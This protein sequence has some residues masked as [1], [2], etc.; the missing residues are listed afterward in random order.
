MVERTEV[1]GEAA[2]RKLAMDLTAPLIGVVAGFVVGVTSTGGG[3]LLTPALVF[4]LR[5]P[6]SIAVGS[7]VLIATVT[8]L[9]GGGLYA[10]RGQVHWPTV[11]RLLAGSLPGA[12]LGIVV[13]NHIPP[14]VREDALQRALGA[15]LV[16]AGAATLGRLYF[17][18]HARPTTAPGAGWTAA[19][20]FG[21]GLLVSTTSIGSGS[22]LLCVLT[23]F[24]PLP[25]QTM[26]G[27]D[28]VHA[29]VLS[30]AATVGHVQAGRVDVA[31]AAS[32]LAGSV[33]GVILGARVAHVVPERA[34]RAV[35]AVILMGLGVPIAW[36][37]ALAYVHVG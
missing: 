5:V 24:F 19:L 6:P 20:G 8:K 28:L 27:T 14:A 26:V 35:L 11:W 15:V 9:F 37:G 29:L 32:V 25:A 4:I 7:D 2:E 30:A 17:A 10:L 12:A 33:P 31:L 36:P 16:L 22:L 13:L 23:I 1:D 3:A 21:T 34:L 18:S